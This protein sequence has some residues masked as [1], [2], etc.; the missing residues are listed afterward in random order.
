MRG[1]AGKALLFQSTLLLASSAF[2]VFASADIRPD[3]TQG[4]GSDSKDDPVTAI[5]RAASVTI[6]SWYVVFT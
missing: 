5:K 3:N 4:K 2:Q 6:G 1:M